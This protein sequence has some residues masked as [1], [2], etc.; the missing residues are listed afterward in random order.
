MEEYMSEE[1]EKI[2]K[3]EVL[4]ML[5]GGRDSFLTTCKMI[6][7]GYHVHLVTY[8]NGCITGTDNVE[9][10]YQRLVDRFGE[11]RVS[12][13]GVCPI[14]QNI[15]NFL[16][17][18]IYEESIEICK[19]YPHLITNQVNCLVCHSV[20]Y[21]HTI[22]YCKVHGIAAIAEGAREQQSFFVELPEMKERY[23]DLCKS[24]GIELH[25]PVYKLDSDQKRKQELAEWGFLPKTYE[26]Q[27]WIGCPMLDKLTDEQR[28]D[29]ARYYDEEML[30]YFSTVIDNLI[31]KKQIEMPYGSEIYI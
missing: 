20:M 19:K 28:L 5:S 31:E 7:K 16:S 11:K 13:V 12:V 8:D 22:A 24:Y 14:A 9:I 21:L 10:L 27:C 6:A 25:M 30:P 26:P 18:I 3:N 4:V 17:K 29:L 15:K 2:K 1:N 23:T